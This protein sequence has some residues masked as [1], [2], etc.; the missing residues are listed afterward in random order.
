MSFFSFNVP[1]NPMSYTGFF[2]S[3][4][5]SWL[6]EIKEIKHIL[7]E[8]GYFNHAGH[9]KIALGGQHV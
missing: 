6:T 9:D 4:S 2:P 1:T 3:L 7:S 8:P 5:G